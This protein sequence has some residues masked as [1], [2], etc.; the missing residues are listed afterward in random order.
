MGGCPGTSKAACDLAREV[1]DSKVGSKYL[2]VL[3][4]SPETA[5]VFDV[6]L[7]LGVMYHMRHP[8]L[9]WSVSLA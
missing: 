1:L 4:H 6:V 9:P 2:D 8:L 3:D 7:F 5:G